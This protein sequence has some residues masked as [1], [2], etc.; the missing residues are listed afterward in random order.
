VLYS[1]AELLSQFCRV[2][3]NPRRS[4]QDKKQLPIWYDGRR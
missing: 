3:L 2:L 1:Q 4:L